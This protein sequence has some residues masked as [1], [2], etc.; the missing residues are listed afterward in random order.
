M[1]KDWMSNEQ[2]GSEVINAADVS[3]DKENFLKIP[4]EIGDI[5]YDSVRTKED[6]GIFVVVGISKGITDNTGRLN[7]EALELTANDTVVHLYSVSDSD[8]DVLLAID[9]RDI[10]RT[11]YLPTETSISKIINTYLAPGFDTSDISDKEKITVTKKVNISDSINEKMRANQLTPADNLPEDI[12]RITYQ[13][14]CMPE[15]RFVDI[16]TKFVY[17]EAVR[18]GRFIERI[19]E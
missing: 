6:T 2:H 9:E 10:G 11:Y 18:I 16:I 15:E 13:S 14:S 4:Y 3:Q 8:D 7:Y 19:S 17:D 12:Y 5:F 1:S